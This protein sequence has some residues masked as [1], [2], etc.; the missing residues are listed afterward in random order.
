MSRAATAAIELNDAEL[1]VVTPAGVVATEPGYAILDGDELIV[2]NEAYGEASLKPRQ[3]H[4]RFWAD[5]DQRP[6]RGG[7]LSNADLAYTQLS[8]LWELIADHVKD[9]VFVVPASFRREQLALLL[10]IAKA[11]EIPVR[12]LVDAGV[13]SCTRARPGARL[14]HWDVGLHA[15]VLSDLSQGEGISHTSFETIDQHGL[16][17]LREGWVSCIGHAFIAQTRFDPLH[18]A[19]SEQ[20]LYDGLSGFLATLGERDTAPVQIEHRN[21]SRGAQIR[22]SDLIRTA[23]DLYRTLIVRAGLGADPDTP[24][25]AH[26]SHRLAD[27]PGFMD[28]MRGVEP[29]EIVRLAPEAPC[30]GALE[31]LEQIPRPGRGHKLVQQLRWSRAT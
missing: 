15:A 20:A 1:R 27:L 13:A 8:R 26:A 2:G 30:M 19:K 18:D 10:G 14:L 29:L 24:V 6:I 4:N 11:C 28:A 9:V 25:V 3:V 12:G 22:R 21:V 5:L 16:M 31:R 17:S 7:S 23:A